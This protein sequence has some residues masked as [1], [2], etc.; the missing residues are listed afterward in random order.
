MP[1]IST[2]MQHQCYV[3]E[4]ALIRVA[5]KQGEADVASG[6]L[7]SPMQARAMLRAGRKRRKVSGG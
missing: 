1:A 5:I 2:A 3:A 6:R 4:R 7:Y